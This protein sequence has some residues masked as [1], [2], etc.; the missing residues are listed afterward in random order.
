MYQ[1]K[2]FIKLRS[3]LRKT[4]FTKCLAKFYIKKDYEAKFENSLLALIKENDI[5]YDI[6]ANR[7]FYTKKFLLKATAGKVFA[8]EPVP[9]C[10]VVIS[11]LLPLYKNLVVYPFALSSN[12]GEFPMSIGNDKL[13]ATSKLKTERGENDILVTVKTLDNVIQE[14]KT[15]PN[16]IKI[17]VEGYELEVLKGMK[18]TLKNEKVMV[19]AIE[20][21]FKLLENNGQ[22]DAPHQIV[23]TLTQNN[24]KVKW[25][26]PSHIIATRGRN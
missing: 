26:D 24:F 17:D 5:I 3:F 12:N 23:N 19:V 14:N 2:L 18:A 25:I 8:F 21:H 16:V 7:G 22:K 20:V 13:N 10:N 1:E 6:G 15:V 9:E 11:D 4:G